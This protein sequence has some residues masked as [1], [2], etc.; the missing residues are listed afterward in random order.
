MENKT[1]V[2]NPN[3]L[4]GVF[5]FSNNSKEDFVAMWNNIEYTFPAMTCSPMLI[6]G[7]PPENVQEIRKRFAL[8]WAEWQWFKS[9]DYQKMVKMGEANNQGIPPLR[10][11]SVLDPLVQQCLTPLPLTQAT[12]KK[13]TSKRPGLSGKSKPIDDNFDMKEKIKDVTSE[14]AGDL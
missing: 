12:T 9:K 3:Y 2:A 1:D 5:Y 8:K 11:D 10:N 4:N 6:P 7:E 14:E 13:V